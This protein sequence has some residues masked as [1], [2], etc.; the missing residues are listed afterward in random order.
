MM[1]LTYP[2]LHTFLMSFK[3]DNKQIKY[4]YLHC[5][6]EKNHT[7]TKC[8]HLEKEGRRFK[9]FTKGYSLQ[10]RHTIGKEACLQQNPG[11]RTLKEEDLSW[12]FNA[13]QVC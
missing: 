11:T 6:P 7:H 9:I 12:E 13:I 5:Q 10:G 8:K 4:V 1:M 3:I 2:C